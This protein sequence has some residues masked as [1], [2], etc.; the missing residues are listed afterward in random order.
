[1]FWNKKKY[2]NSY[3]TVSV[4]G[5][6][7]RVRGNSI[8][9]INDQIIVDGK[10]LEEALDQP[11]ITVIVEGDCRSLNACGNVEVKGNAHN[12]DCRGSC[13]VEGNVTGNV[14]ASGSVTCGDVGGA[15]DACTAYSHKVNVVIVEE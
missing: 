15:I 2:T 1:M 9:I 3:S 11:N 8:S 12:I 4:N 7:V 13:H 5:K 14:N 6:T 10:P